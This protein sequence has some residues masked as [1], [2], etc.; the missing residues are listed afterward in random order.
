MKYLSVILCVL[1][2]A[3]NISTKSDTNTDIAARNDSLLLQSFKAQEREQA[4]LDSLH[5]EYWQRLADKEYEMDDYKIRPDFG[6]ELP[7]LFNECDTL[8]KQLVNLYEEVSNYDTIYQRILTQLNEEEIY[9]DERILNIIQTNL[10]QWKNRDIGIPN[11][12]SFLCLYNAQLRV[13][14]LELLQKQNMRDEGIKSLLRK[15]QEDYET[16]YDSAYYI[17]SLK[18]KEDETY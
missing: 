8:T 1:L 7:Q 10:E 15:S 2:N 3:C 9:V 11:T 16:L 13:R 14:I 4:V 5:N 17:D 6:L 18:I 12:K